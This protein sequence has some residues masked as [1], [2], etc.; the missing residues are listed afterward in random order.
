MRETGKSK[1]T[2]F[3]NDSDS[4]WEDD[5]NFYVDQYKVGFKFIFYTMSPKNMF[6]W[7]TKYLSIRFLCNEIYFE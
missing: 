7:K 1:K 2:G 5:F 3:C 6:L 4:D